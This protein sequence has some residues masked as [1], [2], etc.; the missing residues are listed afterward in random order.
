MLKFYGFSSSPDNLIRLFS[1]LQ[2]DDLERIEMKIICIDNLGEILD[3]VISKLGENLK[4]LKLKCE[5]HCRRICQYQ[6]RETLTLA[7]L[8]TIMTKCPKLKKLEIHGQ[9]LPDEYLCQIE[10][11]SNFQLIVDPPKAKSMKRFKLFYQFKL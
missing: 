11:K 6:Y 3:V 10:K 5:N 2:L 1:N 8:K 4:Q 9:N 7:Q